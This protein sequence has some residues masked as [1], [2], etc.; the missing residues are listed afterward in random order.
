VPP[1]LQSTDGEPLLLAIDHF[2]FEPS[3]HSRVAQMI[4]SMEGVDGCGDEDPTE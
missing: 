3:E 4:Q 1:T 2:A